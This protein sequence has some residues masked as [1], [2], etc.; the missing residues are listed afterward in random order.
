MRVYLIRH[1]QT[2][3]NAHGRAQ[4]HTDIELDEE[5]REQARALGEAARAGRI[6]AH[7]VVTSDLV[8]SAETAKALE[9]VNTLTD[10]RLRER[11]FG[12]WEGLPFEEI[13]RQVPGSGVGAFEFRPPGGESFQDVWN[14]VEP[15]AAELFDEKDPIAVVTHGGTCAILLAQLLKGTQATPR[16]FRFGNTGVTELQRRPDGLFTM[17]RYN[18]LTHL[19]SPAK[20]GDL[21]GSRR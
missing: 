17:I 15:V 8:R 19:S 21:D 3:W 20:S 9:C 13:H 14:R 4:G 7:K 11:S 12:E 1:G 16:A 5:G 2:A 6:R 10:P 18:D